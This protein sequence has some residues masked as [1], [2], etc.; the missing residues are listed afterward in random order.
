MLYQ[1]LMD[2]LT[3]LFQLWSY[4]RLPPPAPYVGHS[5]V[6]LVEIWKYFFGGVLGT[7][8]Y[9]R[10]WV[11]MKERQRKNYPPVRLNI[12]GEYFRSEVI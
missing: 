6:E 9:Y 3:P 12:K 7:F 8:A 5:Y 11:K 1:F 10:L 4:V 2:I